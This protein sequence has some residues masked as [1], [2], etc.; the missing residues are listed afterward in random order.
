MPF[1][2][3]HKFHLVLGFLATGRSG[4]PA[5]RRSRYSPAPFL[6]CRATGT[7]STGR[8][9]NRRPTPWPFWGLGMGSVGLGW[10]VILSSIV[11]DDQY[12]I[13]SS[14]IIH[15]GWSIMISDRSDGVLTTQIWY[16][17]GVEKSQVF[18]V[19]TWRGINQDQPFQNVLFQA[20]TCSPPHAISAKSP[21]R[22]DSSLLPGPEAAMERQSSLWSRW[23]ARSAPS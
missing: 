12:S 1:L 16:D 6:R 14:D 23:E 22:H 21:D 5:P 15:M 19:H 8:N 7:R 17:G 2:V 18:I 11:Y 13:L 4:P 3:P 9:G 10:S 20:A